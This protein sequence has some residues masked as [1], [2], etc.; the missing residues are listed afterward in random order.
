MEALRGVRFTLD[1]RS[2]AGSG[3]RGAGTAG[4]L[5][6]DYHATGELVPPERMRLALRDGVPATLVIIGPRAWRDGRPISPTALRTLAHPLALLEQAREPGTASVAGLGF[7]RGNV[8]VRYRVDRGDRGIVEVELGLFDD[9]IRRQSFTVTEAAAP[10]GTG[11]ATVRTS[12]RV[13]YWD[14]GL[15]LEIG[16][17]N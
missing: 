8:T 3:G 10:D 6:L 11:L 4:D 17:P 5:T 16:E 13:E 12:Y 14:F 15:P 2:V 9:L 1:A 7:A